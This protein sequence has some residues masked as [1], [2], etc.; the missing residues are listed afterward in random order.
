MCT[1]SVIKN[2]YKPNCT[3][4][5]MTAIHFI[6]PCRQCLDFSLCTAIYCWIPFGEKIC[7]EME[8]GENVREKYVAGTFEKDASRQIYLVGEV[9]QK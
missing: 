3:Y 5:I 1:A 7:S 9:D 8:E 2:N 4:I 6:E